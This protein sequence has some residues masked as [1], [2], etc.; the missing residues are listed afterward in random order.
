MDLIEAGET[1]VFVK[2]NN[3]ELVSIKMDL[4]Q[5][6]VSHIMPPIIDLTLNFTNKNGYII[7]ETLVTKSIFV[8]DKSPTAML[9]LTTKTSFSIFEDTC[10]TSVAQI[11]DSIKF[12]AKLTQDAIQQ[13]NGVLAQQIGNTPLEFCPIF[14]DPEIGLVEFMVRQHLHWLV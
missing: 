6:V 8:L 3:I 10:L 4:S 2:L 7:F 1:G 9:Q 5:F 13:N 11:N 14:A 12:F